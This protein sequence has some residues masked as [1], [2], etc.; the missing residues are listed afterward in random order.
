MNTVSKKQTNKLF[1]TSG[2]IT[3]KPIS[4]KE[5]NDKFIKC[6]CRNEEFSKIYDSKPISVHCIYLISIFF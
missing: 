4:I 3:I 1:K 5:W 2:K 6:S